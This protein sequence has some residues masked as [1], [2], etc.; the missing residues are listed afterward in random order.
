MILVGERALSLDDIAEI[1][2]NGE[3]IVLEEKALVKVDENFRFLQGFSSNKLIYGINTGFGPMHPGVARSPRR[4]AG[5]PT[6]HA[7]GHSARR[8][9]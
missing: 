6:I 4:R 8:T 2:F 3:E 1:L 9:V 5:A 7:S